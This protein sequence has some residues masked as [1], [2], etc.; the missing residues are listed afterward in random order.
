MEDPE[1]AQFS[2]AATNLVAEEGAREQ[3]H[4]GS[5][6]ARD[7]PEGR[8]EKQPCLSA[9]GAVR[10]PTWP[11]RRISVSRETEIQLVGQDIDFLEDGLSHNFL[12][13]PGCHGRAPTQELAGQKAHEGVQ[14]DA[15]QRCS[16]GEK[17]IYFTAI[18]T[19]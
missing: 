18:E 7:M 2:A 11:A 8:S 1:H 6:R 3:P 16:S 13:L 17:V 10:H 5:S 12:E 9:P 14:N 4:L 15:A 19:L